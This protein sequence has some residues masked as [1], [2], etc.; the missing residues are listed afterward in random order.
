MGMYTEFVIDCKLKKETPSEII[1]LIERMVKR[2][3]NLPFTR[4]P[5]DDYCGTADFTP[6]FDNLILKAHGCIK[7]Y[8]S[9]IDCF[10][11]IIEK[12]V[13]SGYAKSLYEEDNEWNFLFLTL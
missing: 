13:E 6:S 8:C 4:N 12:W 1:S 9:D 3:E 11:E 2:D 7:N 5:L 10:V